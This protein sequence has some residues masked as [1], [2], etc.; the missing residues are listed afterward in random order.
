MHHHMYAVRRLRSTLIPLSYWQ[1]ALY[2]RKIERLSLTTSDGVTIAA[3]LFPCQQQDLLIVCHGFGANQRSMAIV[4]L[5]EAL[6]GPWDVLTF[7]WRGFGQSGGQASLGLDE[8]QDLETVIAYGRA[9]GYE[10]IGLIAESM[11]GL[12]SLTALGSWAAN[13]EPAEHHRVERLVSIAAP[14][15]YLLTGRLRSF[16]ASHVAPQRWARPLSPLVGLRLGQIKPVSSMDVVQ[17]I[18]VPTLLIH[19]DADTVVP[20]KNAYLIHER[21]PHATLHI[22][23]GVDHSIE[24]MRHSVKDR[25]LEDVRSHFQTW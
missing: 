20:V 22:Y 13:G 15:S 10:R 6:A 21:C 5:A 24:Y 14:I 9:A 25:L 1:Q 16:I 3:T 18:Q 11:G 2:S 7:D 19:G 8:Q 4:W 17:Y 12:I 23:K